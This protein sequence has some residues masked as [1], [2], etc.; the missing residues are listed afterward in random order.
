MHWN[1]VFSA[2]LQSQ[3]IGVHNYDVP[4]MMEHISYVANKGRLWY[5]QLLMK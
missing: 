3:R 2:E 4:T 5:L 1:R